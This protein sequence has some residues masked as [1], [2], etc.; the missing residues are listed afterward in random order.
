MSERQTVSSE[1]NSLIVSDGKQGKWALMVK[2]S[3]FYLV[4]AHLWLSLV[5]VAV[6]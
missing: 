3:F 4:I 1:N 5:T 6:M 2:V